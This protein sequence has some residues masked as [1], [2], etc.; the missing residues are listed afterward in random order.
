MIG[1]GDGGTKV[2]TFTVVRSGGTAAFNV[3]YAT[4]D[5]SATTADGDYVASSNTLQF[6]ANETSK[7]FS[8]VINGDTK[9]EANETFNVNLS[10]AT[11]GATISDAQGVGT[12]SNDDAAAVAGSV[13]ISDVMIGE[14]NAGTKVVTFTVVRS[15]GTAAFNVNYATADGSATTADGDYVANSNTLQFAA[16]ETSKTFSV[17]INGDTKAEANETFNVNL[18]GATNGATISDAQGVGTI[19]NDDAAAVAG[20][21]AIG[22]VMISEGNSGTKVATF[23]VIRSGGTAAFNVNYATADGS[24]TTADGD[25]VAN[26]STLQFAANETSKTFSVVINGDTKVEANETF[27][28]NLSGATNGA[29]ISDAQGVGTITNDDVGNATHI[30]GTEGDDWLVGEGANNVT[31]HGLGGNDLI[32]D[33]SSGNFVFGDNGGDQLYFQ[34]DQNQLY[35]GEGNDWLGVNGNNNALVGGAGDECWIGA[36]GNGNTLAGGDGGDAL[37]A[38]GTG[39]YLHGENGNDWL[40]VS[41]SQNRLYGGAGSEWMGASGNGNLLF[42]GE[43]G[44]TLFSV[45]ANALYGETGDDW[46]GCSGNGNVLNGAQGNDYLAASGN[47]NTLDGGAG[48]DILLAGGAHGGDRF[49]FHVGYGMDTVVNFSRHGAGG[50][51]IVDLNGFG[52][53]FSSLQGYM[54]D[55]GGNCVITLDAATSPDDRRDQQGTAASQRLLVLNQSRCAI[56][57]ALSAQA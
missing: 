46:I 45:G 49:V 10:G 52:L 20:S 43:G 47:N 22:D 14:G 17:V 27:N 40:G 56:K 53:N 26:S 2:M 50:S 37:F 9:V 31:F 23:T 19:S 55:V 6:A 18:S 1:E 39:N 51:D 35:G 4:A 33:V 5:G 12:I 48:N 41:G 3:N 38:N 16:N 25:Y 15:G 28:V 36:S 13:A 42:G 11:N 34:G 30:T 57:F 32:T 44:D 7:T 24:A 21:V 8:V 29:T 54:A